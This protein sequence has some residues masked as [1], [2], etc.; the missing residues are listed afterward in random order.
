MNVFEIMSLIAILTNAGI[1][2]FTSVQLPKLVPGMS[3][4]MQFAVVVIF[5]VCDY[6][7]VE[8]LLS[9]D[10]IFVAVFSAWRVGV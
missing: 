9:Q 10:L 8:S 3:K 7:T 6:C 5:E 1:I 4:L 2:C